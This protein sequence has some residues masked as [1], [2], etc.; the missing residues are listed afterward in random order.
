MGIESGDFWAI[1]PKQTTPPANTLNYVIQLIAATI[2]LL[3]DKILL[4]ERNAVC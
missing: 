2:S 3:A 4:P 1:D